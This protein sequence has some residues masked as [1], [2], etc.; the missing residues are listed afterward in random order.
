MLKKP[1]LG[2]STGR[3]FLDKMTH[4]VLEFGLLSVQLHVGAEEGPGRQ[5]SLLAGDAFGHG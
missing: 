4:E 2:L 5:G 1:E 3:N